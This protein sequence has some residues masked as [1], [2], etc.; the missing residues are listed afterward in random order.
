MLSL[1]QRGSSVPDIDFQRLRTDWS[2]AG[3]LAGSLVGPAGT[4]V[5]AAYTR[6]FDER[7]SADDPIPEYVIQAVREAASSLEGPEDHVAPILGSALAHDDAYVILQGH[8][9]TA[10]AT[11]GVL[12][13]DE[14]VSAA[15]AAVLSGVAH[16]QLQLN[17]DGGLSYTPNAQ[18]NGVD[19][20]SY[21]ALGA[22]GAPDIGSASIYVA[23]V[24][25]GASTTLNELALTPPE[26][27]AAL[28]IAFLGRAPDAA[29]FEYW[30]NQLD[31][32]LPTQGAKVAL[33]NVAVAI[34]AS[35][36]AK[37]HSP[38]AAKATGDITP[39]MYQQA[40]EQRYQEMLNRPGDDNGMTYW[41]EQIKNMPI[42]KVDELPVVGP[43]MGPVVVVDFISGTQDTAVGKDIT[44]LMSKVAV[45]LDYVKQQELHGTVWAG[46]S[47]KAA[48]TALLQGVTSDPSTLLVGLKNA[49]ALV[50]AHA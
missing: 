20:F 8:S 19:T 48:A 5:Q 44:T 42:Q 17:A 40:L 30:V 47:D 29:G 16:G 3:E 12:A 13:N 21:S 35:P 14:N 10:N 31:E 11:K 46:A 4:A 39:E 6:A 41:V 26:Q 38:L 18:F 49:E 22:I 25:V 1:I 7:T 24:N 33:T 36:E 27:I 15:T 28:Y 9:L 50:A 32:R 23:P 43:V 34:A 37:A 45:S 2:Y